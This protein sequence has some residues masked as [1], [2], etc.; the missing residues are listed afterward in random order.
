MA[1][2][3]DIHEAARRARAR[4]VRRRA[5]GVEKWACAPYPAGTPLALAGG[6]A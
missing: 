6:M 1:A 5:R 3:P 4:T 2:V